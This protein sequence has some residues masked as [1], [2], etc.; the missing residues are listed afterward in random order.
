[1]TRLCRFLLLGLA[2]SLL[3][4]APA[5]SAQSAAGAR[6]SEANARADE[7]GNGRN[8][9]R[10]EN[11]GARSPVREAVREVRDSGLAEVRL[12]GLSGAQADNVRALVELLRLNAEQRAAITPGRLAFLLRRAPDELRRAME[13]FGYYAVSVDVQVEASPRGAVVLLQVERGPPVRVR[14]FDVGVD[15]PGADD[16]EVQAALRA[17]APRPGG[18]FNHP[19][20]ESSKAAVSRALAAR[21]F[22]EARLVEQR[23]EVTRAESRAAVRL[24][25]DSGPRYAFGEGRVEGS[26]L[27]PQLA[28]RWLN[29]EP[30]EPF[31]QQRLARLNQRLTDLDYFGFIDI[32][33]EPDA[34]TGAADVVIGV[35]PAAQ[36]IYSAGVSFGTDSGAGLRLGWDRR[37]VNDRGHKFDSRLDL[38]QR[39][40]ALNTAYRVPAFALVEGWYT[41]GLSVREDSSDTVESD[42]AELVAS[43]SGRLGDWTLSTAVHVQRERYRIGSARS[44][45]TSGIDTLVYPALRAR[46]HR[47]D[48]PMYSSRGLTFNTELKGGSSAIGSDVDF[49]QVLLEARWLRAVGERTRVLLRG[50]VGRTFSDDLLELPSSLRF[51]AGGDRSVRGYNFQEISPLNAAGD[52]IGGRNLLVSSVEFERMFSETWGAAVFLDAG[53]AF[54]R[55][56]DGLRRGAGIGLRWRSPVGP[57]NL[58]VARGLDDPRSPWQLHLTLGPEL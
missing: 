18:I 41:L 40:S 51:F 34:E 17:F 23:V 50:Q 44:F 45:G 57:V 1:M 43:R 26:Q 11:R 30:G 33:P 47:Y 32:R 54:N 12:S 38:A 14:A 5:A 42:I 29:F 3:L 48:H 52:P 6:S 20:Y 19:R 55:R 37:W 27:R 31:E 24:R 22:F 49:A 15:G 10:A 35:V 28:E 36:N 7:R 4:A 53:N 39:R 8:G 25:W 56:S 13:P 58:D 46:Y 2:C 21:G 9:A 16:P